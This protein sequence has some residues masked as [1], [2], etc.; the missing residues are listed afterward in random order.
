MGETNA[1]GEV[2]DRFSTLLV[3]RLTS[4]YGI[5]V[6]LLVLV[7]SIHVFCCFVSTGDSRSLIALIQNSPHCH[8]VR[9]AHLRSCIDALHSRPASPEGKPPMFAACNG[10]GGVA[11]NGAAKPTSAADKLRALAKSATMPVTTAFKG[12][13]GPRLRWWRQ[14][15]AVSPSSVTVRRYGG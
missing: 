3:V 4:T 7:W 9:F 6:L 15:G 11:S 10:D 2:L 5:S 8:L 12:A 13:L 14:P 1:G